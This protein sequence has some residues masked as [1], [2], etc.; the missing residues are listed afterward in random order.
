VNAV[1]L[2]LAVEEDLP[3]KSSELAEYH[4]V[5][6]N[7]SPN[8]VP[9]VRGAPAP[10]L[11]ANMKESTRPILATPIKAIVRLRQLAEAVGRDLP[12]YN[13]NAHGTEEK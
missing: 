7:H 1:K 8:W 13:A 11:G 5:H 3:H 9:R 4:T 12:A 2:S 10:P 6:I